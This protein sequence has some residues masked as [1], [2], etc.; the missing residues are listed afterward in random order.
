MSTDTGT[1]LVESQS[2]THFL[3]SLAVTNKVTR[4]SQLLDTGPV[5]GA[6]GGPLSFC[7]TVGRL[8]GVLRST[9]GLVV[10]PK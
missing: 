1:T 6:R 4:R 10:V 8:D 7:R 2:Y 9:P 3:K 5:A